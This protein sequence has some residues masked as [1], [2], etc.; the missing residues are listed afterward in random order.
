[1]FDLLKMEQLIVNRSDNSIRMIQN[2][3]YYMTHL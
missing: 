3:P 1:M 2:V